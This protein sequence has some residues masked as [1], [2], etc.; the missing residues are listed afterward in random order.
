[1][2]YDL[3]SW[4]ANYIQYIDTYFYRASL[5]VNADPDLIVVDFVKVI[6]LS[7]MQVL[8]VASLHKP[9]KQLIEMLD[10]TR[11]QNEWT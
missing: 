6:N 11:K 4:L 3:I 7:A 9:I 2:K 5:L 10:K 8:Q 1:M